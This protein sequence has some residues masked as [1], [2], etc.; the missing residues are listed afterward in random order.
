MARSRRSKPTEDRR[1][2]V[3]E[4][5]TMVPE[6]R[7]GNRPTN[8]SSRV[9]ITPVEEQA[10]SI[11]T[12]I[13]RR[14]VESSIIPPVRKEL[15]GI[16]GR[17]LETNPYG[18][19]IMVKKVTVVSQAFSSVQWYGSSSTLPYN[20]LQTFVDTVF[21][22]LQQRLLEK[23]RFINATLTAAG[24]FA[25]WLNTY[26]QIFLGL[27]GLEGMLAANGLNNQASGIADA[28]GQS[29]IRIEQDLQRLASFPVPQ[30][31]VDMLDR[32]CGSFMYDPD[33]V[34]YQTYCDP[35]GPNPP[36]DLSNSGNVPVVLGRI[37]GL[38]QSLINSGDNLTIINTLGT[39]FGVPAIGSKSV[40]TDIQ[41]YDQWLTQALSFRNTTSNLTFTAPTTQ[42]TATVVG[43][44]PVLSRK[45]YPTRPWQISVFR[46]PI[47]AADGVPP[48][49]VA[50]TNLLGLLSGGNLNTFGTGILFYTSDNVQGTL[51]SSAAT[52]G[53]QLDSL[54]ISR[55][56]EW[57][58]MS[59]NALVYSS[60]SPKDDWDIYYTSLDV[61]FDESILQMTSMFEIAN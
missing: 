3:R 28:I 37:E 4:E 5:P 34:V 30:G 51:L 33:G 12:G 59:A 46:G 11:K 57:Y 41:E 39:L 55:S 44:Y 9:K 14:A 18:E 27:R 40:D 43:A 22:V 16:T 7:Q 60:F 2:V 36:L 58:M 38:F 26:S 17:I 48:G 19:P 61:L 20:P 29:R 8:R 47:A 13:L 32:L 21:P 1:V 52:Q 24:A 45:R 23:G 25:T 56:L 10:P 42:D 53:T 35:G 15:Q 50:V 6:G 49:G 31:V 54:G